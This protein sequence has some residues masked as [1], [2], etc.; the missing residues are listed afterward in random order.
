MNSCELVCLTLSG[1]G[2]A[3]AGTPPPG[4]DSLIT[5]SFQKFTDHLCSVFVDIYSSPNLP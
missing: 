2:T 1:S 3:S 5:R 4:N